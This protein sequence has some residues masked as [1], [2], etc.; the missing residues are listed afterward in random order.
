M[1]VCVIVAALVC[2][3]RLKWCRHKAEKNEKET[4]IERKGE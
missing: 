1:C 4:E 2:V 3:C